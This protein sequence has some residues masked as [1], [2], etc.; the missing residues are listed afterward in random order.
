MACFRSR[1]LHRLSATK[2]AKTVKS[3]YLADGGGLYLQTSPSATKSW[4][5]LFKR[6]GRA[7]E[8]GLGSLDSVSLAEARIKAAACRKQLAEGINPLE[9]RRACLIE[10]QASANRSKTFSDCAQTYIAA[11]RGTWTNPKHAAQWT[12]TLAKYAEPVFGHMLVSNID[13]NRVVEVLD[14]IW[15]TKPETASRVRGRIEAVLD[16]A[17]VKHYRDG[18]NPARWRGHLDK[19]LAAPKR[20]KRSNHHA[21]LPY[22]NLPSFMREL[23]KQRGIAARALE[24]LI[25]TGARTGEIIGSSPSEFDLETV[26]WTV[27]AERMKAKEMHRVPLSEDAANLV[28]ALLVSAK[29]QFLFP[30]TKEGKSLSNMAML[31]LLVRMKYTNMTVHGFRSTFRDWAAEC[32]DHSREVAEAALAH[33]IGNKVEA[34]YRRGELL[35]KR[36]RLMDD[37]ADYCSG[38]LSPPKRQSSARKN[39]KNALVSDLEEAVA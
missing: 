22:K 33:A 34:A 16:W 28:Q 36:R 21:A 37:W 7:R 23:R 2:V 15:Q 24:L 10:A 38:K 1:A 9:A 39:D 29:G 30:G 32:T 31:K 8:M 3:G 19:L 6:D 25:L 35:E 14:P 5:F 17:K 20:I 4:I 11:H 26:L 27:P 13:T 12:S 18:E